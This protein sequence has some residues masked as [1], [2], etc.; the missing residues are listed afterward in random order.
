MDEFNYLSVLLSL[1][2]G[3]A[4]TQILKGYRGIVLARRRVRLY[5]PSVLWSASL[6]LLNV[7]SWWASFDLREVRVWTFAGFATLLAQTIFQYMLAA[8]VF[9]DFFGDEAVDLR[10]HYFAHVRAFFGLAALVLAASVA[11]D[12]VIG[13]TWPRPLDLVFHAVF[14]TMLAIALLTRSEFV[15]KAIAL[16][17]AVLLCAYI[18]ELFA[19]LR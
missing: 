9:P 4:I 5:W 3:L 17:V 8:I 10:A 16:I 15:H 12:L 13:G 6:L 14:A 1:I 19:Q 7:Q 11:K 2:I 18:V